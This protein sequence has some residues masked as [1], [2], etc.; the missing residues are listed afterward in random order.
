M[1]GWLWDQLGTAV[2]DT[3]TD[4]DTVRAVLGEA[5][6]LMHRRQVQCLLLQ[7]VGYSQT[8]IAVLMGITTRAVRYSFSDA[9]KK[10]KQVAE[11][12]LP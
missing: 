11:K 9:I 1:D 5:I 4:R 3:V 12:N 10:V 2:E 6:P 8:E 7:L